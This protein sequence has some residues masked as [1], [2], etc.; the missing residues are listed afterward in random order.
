MFYIK[1]CIYNYI[2][3]ELWLFAISHSFVQLKE[4]SLYDDR[5]QS[6]LVLWSVSEM[7]VIHQSG[8]VHFH[9]LCPGLNLRLRFFS[10]T[11]IKPTNDNCFD[12]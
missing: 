2:Y 5:I 1:S 7:A 9:P 3:G 11:C 6:V 10:L 4:K 8:Q 12:R